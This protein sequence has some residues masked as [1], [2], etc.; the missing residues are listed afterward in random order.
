M[1]TGLEQI[2]LSFCTVCTLWIFST[3]PISSTSLIKVSKSACSCYVCMTDTRGTITPEA[4]KFQI[5]WRWRHHFRSLDCSLSTK[6]ATTVAAV[7]G[8]WSACLHLFEYLFCVMIGI[9][10]NYMVQPQSLQSKSKHMFLL[11]MSSECLKAVWNVTHSVG[12]CKEKKQWLWT[13]ACAFGSTLL[14]WSLHA[15]HCHDD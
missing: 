4:L 12:Q 14:S 15:E 3:K 1:A 6:K 10:A 13:E 7:G 8:L 5:Y 2:F 9:T 11:H